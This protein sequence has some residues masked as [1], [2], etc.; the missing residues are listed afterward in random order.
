MFD[1][2]LVKNVRFM[3]YSVYIKSSADIFMSELFYSLLSVLIRWCIRAIDVKK[4][5]TDQEERGQ[6]LKKKKKF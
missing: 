6:Y 2:H 4:E 3:Q 5:I 1:D